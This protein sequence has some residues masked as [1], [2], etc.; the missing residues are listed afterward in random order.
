MTEKDLVEV[1]IDRI[2]QLIEKYIPEPRK[3]KINKMFE[4]IGEFYFT[5]PASSKKEYHS[6]FDGGLAVHSLNVFENL[7]KLNEAFAL[8]FSMESML[9]TCLFH[10]LGKAVDTTCKGPNYTSD[11]D[12]WQKERGIMYNYTK[13]GL[14]FSNHQ[15]SMFILQKY[16]VELT[17][18][19]YQAILLNDGMYLDA[20]KAYAHKQCLLSL[21][22]HHADV[23][24]SVQE[25]G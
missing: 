22:V 18:E 12:K 13:Q 8:N 23:A 24:A 1:S 4:E 15:K 3:T 20:N 17:A 25:K 19:E 21:Y 9:I 2:T 14:Y 10:D 6:A 7:K 5:A 16:G 11:T